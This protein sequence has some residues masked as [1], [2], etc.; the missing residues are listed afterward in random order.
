MVF[1]YLE[2]PVWLN[3][4]LQWF[5]STSLNRSSS[6]PWFLGKKPWA[7]LTLNTHIL[8]VCVRRRWWGGPWCPKHSSQIVLLAQLVIELWK[9]F[10]KRSKRKK[11]CIL[12]FQKCVDS[13]VAWDLA[14]E[15][16][17]AGLAQ[18]RF[19]F[20]MHFNVLFIAFLQCLVIHPHLPGKLI[21]L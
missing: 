18:K 11:N 1:S 17:K 3:T 5:E 19:I 6:I 9:T 10:L 20:F 4:Y 2:H 12:V 16:L 15:R 13:P 14:L 7:W 8:C 21:T